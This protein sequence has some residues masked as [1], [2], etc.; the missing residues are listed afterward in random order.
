LEYKNINIYIYIKF[1]IF[2]KKKKKKKKGYFSNIEA[3]SNYDKNFVLYYSESLQLLSIKNTTFE[4]IN[5]ESS[6][7][8]I[9]SLKLMIE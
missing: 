2:T 9:E 3:N 8:L 7:P 4:N 6:H 1:I 5:I